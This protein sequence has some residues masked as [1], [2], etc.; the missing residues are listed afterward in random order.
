MKVF[1]ELE[2][3]TQDVTDADVINYLLE[4]IENDCL[5]Y[6]VKRESYREV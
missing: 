4:L 3:E 2:F 6:E 5:D 1:I